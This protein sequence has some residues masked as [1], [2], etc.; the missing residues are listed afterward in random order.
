MSRDINSG[1]VCPRGLFSWLGWLLVRLRFAVVLFWAA[2]ALAAYLYL[3]PLEGNTTSNL[4]DLVPES[5][6]AVQAYYS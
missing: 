5:A 1:F 2:V 3:P 6:P 4:S